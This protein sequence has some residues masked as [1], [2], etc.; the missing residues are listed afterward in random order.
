MITGYLELQLAKQIS[1]TEEL[2]TG[3]LT[4]NSLDLTSS[5]K[6]DSKTQ[7]RG[8]EHDA[9]NIPEK[10]DQPS[11]RAKIGDSHGSLIGEALN[12]DAEIEATLN[13]EQPRE[14]P[15]DTT[16]DERKKLVQTLQ[17]KS[18][19][20]EK[21][22]KSSEREAGFTGLENKD[23]DLDP[24]DLSDQ[25]LAIVSTQVCHLFSSNE[26]NF[27][28]EILKVITISR[29]AITIQPKGNGNHQ[30]GVC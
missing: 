21:D 27:Q 16:K 22:S 18:T 1:L 23:K 9:S 7:K 5:Q 8:L 2:K 6:T 10:Q 26:C 11:K 29:Q 17:E 20:T 14:N 13:P 4:K 15:K 25:S 3:A 30:S 24:T 19:D 12:H 28:V